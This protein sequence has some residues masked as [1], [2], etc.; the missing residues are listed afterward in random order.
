MADDDHDLGW[1]RGPATPW[2][3][4]PFG[5]PPTSADPW[6]PSKRTAKKGRRGP[7]FVSIAIALAVVAVLVAV[8]VIGPSMSRRF[9]QDATARALGTPLAPPVVAGDTIVVFTS[10]GV[11]GVD[12]DSHRIA[13]TEED[14]PGA[15]LDATERT[16]GDHVVVVCHGRVQSIAVDDGTVEWTKPVPTSDRVRVSDTTIAISSPGQLSVWDAG[17]G[18]SRWTRPIKDEVLPL[19]VDDDRIYS[20]EGATVVALD[21]KTGAT[22]WTAAQPAGWLAVDGDRVINRTEYD[23]LSVIDAATGATVWATNDPDASDSDLVRTR[24]VGVAGGRIILQDEHDNV[25][26]RDL[27]DGTERWKALANDEAPNDVAAGG[28]W[29]AMSYLDRLEVLD[30][31]T[32]GIVARRPTAKS[33]ATI[34]DGRLAY[35]DGEQLEVDDLA[36]LTPGG[37]AGTISTRPRVTT[38]SGRNDASVLTA[39]PG[40]DA[41]ADAL[42]EHCVSPDPTWPLS[43]D[44]V[45]SP[46]SL[47]T[48]W[49]VDARVMASLSSYRG[50]VRRRWT[51]DR[52]DWTCDVVRIDDPAELREVAD[53]IV[54]SRTMSGSRRFLDGEQGP[55]NNGYEAYGTKDSYFYLV[56]VAPRVGSPTPADMDAVRAYATNLLESL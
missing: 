46:A 52:V 28:S 41:T 17:T 7:V 6:D 25:V 10:S 43:I 36:T 8:A 14:C 33:G 22:V 23:Q 49:G 18:E 31:A 30:A 47:V 11:T 27:A 20:G 3:P 9:G 21:A 51:S 54:R 56:R 55:Y 5:V 45:I 2:P 4:G 12:R 32:G 24:V 13:W 44:E 39:P 1:G 37:A 50:G 42:R 53:P 29:I 19:A 34:A 16:A 15:P 38:P 48:D 40:M 35:V 26:A